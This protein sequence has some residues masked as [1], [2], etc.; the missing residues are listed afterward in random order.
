MYR[1][2]T[3]KQRLRNGENVLGCWSMLGHPPVIE[4]LGLAGFDFVVIDHEH[5]LGDPSSLPVQLQALSSALLSFRF[6]HRGPHFCRRARCPI[7]CSSDQ[8]GGNLGPT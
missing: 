7:V 5:G 1:T 2:N 6:L 3:L 8:S 4:L